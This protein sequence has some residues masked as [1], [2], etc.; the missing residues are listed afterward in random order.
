MAYRTE[1]L[2]SGVSAGAGRIVRLNRAVA[3]AEVFGAQNAL[4]ELDAI[5][6]DA[7]DEFL[8]FHAVRAD[9]LRRNGRNI[10]ALHAYEVAISPV[11]TAA[12]RR[13]LTE[14]RDAPTALYQLSG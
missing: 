14:K 11:T 9:L 13:W 7:I 5:D 4:Q 1:S 6:A 12:E 10:E 3:L 2:K 8:L